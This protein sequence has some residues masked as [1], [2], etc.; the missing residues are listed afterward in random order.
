MYSRSYLQDGGVRP[1]QNYDGIALSE[2]QKLDTPHTSFQ[3]EPPVTEAVTPENTGQKN[4]WEKAN[5][6]A[7]DGYEA[8]GGAARGGL[9]LPLLGGLFEGLDIPFFGKLGMPKIGTEELL[10]IGAALFLLLSKDGDKECALILLL[11]LLVN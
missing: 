11:L 7:S 2:P 1:P 9:K 6:P 8:V 10:I 4:P 5:A 3:N